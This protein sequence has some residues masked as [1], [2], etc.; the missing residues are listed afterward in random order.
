MQVHAA[1]H[2]TGRIRL[3]RA[4]ILDKAAIAKSRK[5]QPHVTRG[6]LLSPQ[7]LSYATTFCKSVAKHNPVG[8]EPSPKVL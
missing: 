1:C 7:A 3:A 5:Q 6:Q 2:Q 8:Q 4:V